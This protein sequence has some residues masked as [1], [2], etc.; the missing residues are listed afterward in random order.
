MS[1]YMPKTAISSAPDRTPSGSDAHAGSP[2]I[3][4]DVPP[5]RRSSA[6]RPLRWPSTR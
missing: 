6:T 3:R 4:S 2:E 5:S 1:Q